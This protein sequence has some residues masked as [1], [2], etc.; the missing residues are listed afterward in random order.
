MISKIDIVQ[1]AL[2]LI[3]ISG[4]TVQASPAEISLGVQTLDD[5]AAELE[6]TLKTGYLQPSEYGQSDPNDYSGLTAGMVAP[7]KKLLALQLTP[8]YGKE[9]PQMLYN[10]LLEELCNI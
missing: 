3:R 7:M 5:Y 4:L 6:A 9:V 1:G 10:K 2:E 8:Y